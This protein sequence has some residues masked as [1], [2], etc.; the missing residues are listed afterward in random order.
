[1]EIKRFDN[2]NKQETTKIKK[3]TRVKKLDLHGM[4]WE[5]K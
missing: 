4:Q 3:D 2:N 5:K 1:M